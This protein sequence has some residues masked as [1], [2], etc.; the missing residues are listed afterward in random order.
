M[1][2]IFE[3]FP[4]GTGMW[5]RRREWPGEGRLM[6]HMAASSDMGART[7]DTGLLTGPRE[8][9]LSISESLIRMRWA[10]GMTSTVVLIQV[11]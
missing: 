3:Q 5:A 6:W 2:A 10:R 8:E 11:D 9:M 1:F 7:G 4:D